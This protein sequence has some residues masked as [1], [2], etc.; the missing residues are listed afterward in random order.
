MTS[1]DLGHFSFEISPDDD[2]LVVVVV[3]FAQWV[4]RMSDDV[5]PPMSVD[6]VDSES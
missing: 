6:V 4:Q 5:V 3:V 1:T 2:A